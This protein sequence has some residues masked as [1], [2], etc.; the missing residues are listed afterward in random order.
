MVIKI[1]KKGD[2]DKG[3]H[4]LSLSMECFMQSL[5]VFSSCE[6]LEPEQSRC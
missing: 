4:S 5:A 2:I 6:G 3:Q 1:I